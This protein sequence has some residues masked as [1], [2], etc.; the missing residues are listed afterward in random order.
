MLA[1]K[2][3]NLLTLQFSDKPHGSNMYSPGSHLISS[4]FFFLTQPEAHLAEE[5]GRSGGLCW[6]H[7]AFIYST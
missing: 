1:E 3:K 5:E 4:F 6:N 2:K 7:S